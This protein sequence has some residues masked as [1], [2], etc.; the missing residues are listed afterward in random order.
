MR[1]YGR[2]C[3]DEDTLPDRIALLK[4]HAAAVERQL[5]ELQG[6]Q[7]KLSSKLYWYQGELA[8]RKAG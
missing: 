8:R 2:L 5:A 3:Q 4:E 6:Q 1:R 7:E